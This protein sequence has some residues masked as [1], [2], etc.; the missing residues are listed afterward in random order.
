MLPSAA[1]HR[2]RC[3]R[4]AAFTLIELLVVIAIIGVLIALLLPAIQKVRAAAARMQCGNN[5]KQLAIGCHAYH[6]TFQVLPPARIARDAYATWPVLIM[7]YIEAQTLYQQWDIRL[8]FSQQ[9][10]DARETTL[11]V[12]FCPARRSPMTCPDSQGGFD[13]GNLGGACG[14]YACCAGDD[15]TYNRTAHPI[16]QRHADGAMINGKVLN[17]P[18]PGPQSGENGW[19]QPNNNP[20]AMPLIPILSF[21]SYTNLPYI[22]DE[23]GT[24]HTFMLGEKHVRRNHFGEAGDG[25]EPYY[26]GYN[27]DSAQRAAGPGLPLA[28]GPDDSHKNHQDM[29]GSWHP[30][31]CQF[32]FCDG[33]VA[34]IRNDIDTTSLGYLA[35]RMD[36]QNISVDH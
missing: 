6:D 23:D 15:R 21:S 20:P 10:F 3:R 33:H 30:S 32:A 17:P 1:F 8:G 2:V 28:Q 9:T 19:D 13:N 31:V 24:A 35:N 29:F 16:N 34:A 5:L 7:P 22:N 26:S 36:H 12:F 4:R 11:K 14:D 27:Y 25:D 18:Q